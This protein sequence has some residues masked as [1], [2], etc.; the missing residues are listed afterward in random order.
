MLT[1]PEECGACSSSS[2][3]LCARHTRTPIH[4]GSLLPRV[5]PLPHRPQMCKCFAVKKNLKNP[6]SNREFALTHEHTHTQCLICGTG[7]AYVIFWLSFFFSLELQCKHTFDLFLLASQDVW[8]LCG[9][10]HTRITQYFPSISK[11]RKP[12]LQ[13]AA[14]T[15]PPSSR[16]W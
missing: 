3:S 7:A 8:H 14:P 1:T 4:P 11:R 12:Y 13:A 16:H 15:R 6:Q 5:P 9:F 10:T 2:S